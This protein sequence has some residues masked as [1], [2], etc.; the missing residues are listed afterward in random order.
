[1][2]TLAWVLISFVGGLVV[3]S[4]LPS[5]FQEKGKN[6]AT[7]ED[8][9]EITRQIEAAKSGFA[10]A[11][12]LQKARHQLR[13]AAL[14]RRLQTHQDAFV[15][16]KGMLDAMGT[17]EVHP[18]LTKCLAWWNQNCVYLE[19]EVRSHFVMACTAGSILQSLPA[20]QNNLRDPNVRKTYDQLMSFHDVLLD[21]MQL[22]R[23]SEVEVQGLGLNK[24]AGESN[25]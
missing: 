17:A 11:L 2:E 21:A 5:Y 7:K 22:P 18:H 24:K 15:L 14:E 1:M 3:R 6:L 4:F 20:G 23:L 10:E 8:I 9:A 13:G 16:W 19:P 25:I 12:E